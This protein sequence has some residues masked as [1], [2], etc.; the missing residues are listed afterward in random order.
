MTRIL[1]LIFLVCSVASLQAQRTTDSV[2][3]DELRL[4]QSLRQDSE[5]Q[6]VNCAQRPLGTLRDNGANFRLKAKEAFAKDGQQVKLKKVCP[7]RE[8]TPVYSYLQVEK[9]KATL[10]ID[11][12]Q[13]KFGQQHVW[14]YL[15]SGLDL[16][17]YFNDLKVGKMVFEKIEPPNIK[18]AEIALQCITNKGEIYF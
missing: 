13:D 18:D 4:S 3:I 17:R 12:T 9:G 10:V 16:G 14:S 6:L 5:Y 1:P 2:G 11:S 15:C 7:T 8:G